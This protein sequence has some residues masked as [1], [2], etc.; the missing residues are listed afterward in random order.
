MRPI[1]DDLVEGNLITTSHFTD[2]AGKF[3]T[4]DETY[5]RYKEWIKSLFALFVPSVFSSLQISMSFRIF[6]GDYGWNSFIWR[7]VCQLRWKFPI[8]ILWNFHFK[9]LIFFN[10]LN[11][12]RISWQP[13]VWSITNK[14]SFDEEILKSVTSSGL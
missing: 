5:S 8:F 14:H 9:R 1:A 2:D 4:S 6:I 7:Y 12:L 10:F 13:S 3:P 11:R